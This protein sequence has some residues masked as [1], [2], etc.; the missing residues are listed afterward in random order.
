MNDSKK[1]KNIEK[2]EKENQKILSIIDETETTSFDNENENST[3]MWS[4]ES[5]PI[6]FSKGNK[7]GTGKKKIQ[8]QYIDNKRR[9]T[10]SFSKRKKGLMKKINEFRTLTGSKVLLL[11]VSESD[12][13]Y[14]F[15]SK[16]LQGIITKQEGQELIKKELEKTN[17]KKEE[18]KNKS[19]ENN[20]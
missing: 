14:A 2:D 16:E 7:I 12:K 3:E 1:K 18:E 17:K 8:I 5:N 15:A 20:Q 11:I 6:S 4:N 19:I 10:V 13:L 9:R